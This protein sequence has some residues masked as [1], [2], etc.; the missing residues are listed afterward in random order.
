VD[1]HRFGGQVG[2]LFD[3]RVVVSPDTLLKDGL[4]G[5]IVHFSKNPKQPP[6]LLYSISDEEF[7]RLRNLPN[8]HLVKARYTIQ[9]PPRATG[10]PEEE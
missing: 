9:I 4:K 2:V 10:A 6:R 5:P 1:Q 7:G 8:S 3:D